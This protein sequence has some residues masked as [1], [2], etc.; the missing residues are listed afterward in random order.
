VESAF[1]KSDTALYDLTA[2]VGGKIKIKI[3]VDKNPPMLFSTEPMLCTLPFSFYVPCFALPDLFAGKM[4]AVL[5]RKWKNRVK[6]RDWYDF[7]WYVRQGVPM[8]LRHF[9]ERAMQSE[10]EIDTPLSRESFKNL[11]LDKIAGLNIAAVR[12]DVRPFLTD[13][14]SLDIWSREYFSAL[15]ERIDFVHEG[16]SP[17]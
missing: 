1:L 14:T 15:S 7:E 16:N 13:R 5:F 9:N 6:G 4:H 12:E 11:L 10:P 17:A 2:D 8:D 3:E